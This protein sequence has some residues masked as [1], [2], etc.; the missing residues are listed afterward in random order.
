MGLLFVRGKLALVLPNFAQRKSDSTAP[1]LLYLGF[2]FPPGIQPLYPHVNPAGHALETQM[3][4]ELRKYFEIRS[5]GVLPFSPG[6]V[7]GAPPDSG[8]DHDLILIEKAPELFHRYSSLL[9]L[10]QQYCHWRASGWVPDVA[11]VYNLSPIYNQFLAWLKHQSSRPRMV[12]LLLDSATLGQNVPRRKQFRRRL[13]PM[14]IP[15][16]K[17]L[18]IFD[19]GIGLSRVVRRYFRERGMPFL[20]MPGACNP[21]RV[22]PLS[23]R[24]PQENGPIRFGYF[25]ALGAHSGV[26]QLIEA[27]AASDV[28]ARLEIC[29]YGKMEE[30]L[31]SMIDQDARLKYHGLKNPDE[32]LRFGAS[33]DVLV[34]P[35]PNTH[36]NENNFASKLFEYALTG[37]TILTSWLS[38]EC[39]VLGSQAYYFDAR[40]YL[41]SLKARLVELAGTPRFVLDLSGMA[42]QR[43]ILSE[44]SWEKQGARMAQF[45]SDISVGQEP[46]LAW[47]P[48]SVGELN[49]SPARQ[50]IESTPDSAV[51]DRVATR[52][53]D[54]IASGAEDCE[55]D[56]LSVEAS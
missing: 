32:C 2:A 56:Q 31:R 9:R 48:V 15:D 18:R 35:R 13:K 46:A 7:Q 19:G 4:W 34:N 29:A 28:K 6:R 8:V 43:R 16:S 17:M 14:Y 27:F 38:G 10:R 36:G 26:G 22:L 49:F 37:R 41:S 33:C 51:P 55:S 5:V 25:G 24:V 53:D 3:V 39:A 52:N 20:W 23:E 11:L 45:L 21:R 30:R 40:A 47:A 44:F 50:L 42:V 54:Y 1:R 12:L